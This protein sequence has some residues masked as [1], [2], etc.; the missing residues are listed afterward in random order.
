MTRVLRQYTCDYCHHDF[1]GIE[2][3]EEEQIKHCPCCE[4][5][6]AKLTKEEEQ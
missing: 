1:D 3:K 6:T 5:E 4:Q 2:R